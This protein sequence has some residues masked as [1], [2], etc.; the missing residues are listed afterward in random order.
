MDIGSVGTASA[1]HGA[2]V[3]F[4]DCDQELTFCLFV[5]LFLTEASPFVLPS[6]IPV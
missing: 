1:N 6:L 2:G 5:F 3:T 4:E